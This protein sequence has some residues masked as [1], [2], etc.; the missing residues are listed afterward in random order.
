[1]D[2]G[3]GVADGQLPSKSLYVHIDVPGSKETVWHEPE[4]TP[5]ALMLNVDIS[6]RRG[7][8]DGRNR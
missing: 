1:V 7:A 2:T 6:K 5:I 3:A 4:T 8:G